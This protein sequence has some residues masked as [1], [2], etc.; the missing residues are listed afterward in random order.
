MTTK[1]RLR[2]HQNDCK[3]SA[4][5]ETRFHCDICKQS[6]R[7]QI[8]LKKHKEKSHLDKFNSKGV[9][10]A[11]SKSKLEAKNDTSDIM[12][13]ELS[14]D[15]CVDIDNSSDMEPLDE[16]YLTIKYALYYFNNKL[17]MKESHS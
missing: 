3:K 14:D 7:K 12:K 5:T 4:T 2:L 17:F 1:A 11:S 13:I 8:S 6:F 10:S 16:E 9:L 15:D